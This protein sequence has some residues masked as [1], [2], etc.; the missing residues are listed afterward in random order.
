MRSPAKVSFLSSPFNLII[1]HTSMDDDQHTVSALSTEHDDITAIFPQT[2]LPGTHDSRSTD[3]G[4]VVKRNRLPNCVST[5]ILRKALFSWVW[6]HGHPISRIDSQGDYIRHWL[7]KIC[8]VE[9]VVVPNGVVTPSDK[10]MIPCAS[11]TRPARH[12]KKHGYNEDGSVFTEPSSKRK[13]VTI[14]DLI[15]K[16]QKLNDTVFDRKGWQSK[17]VSWMTRTGTSLRSASSDALYDL[18]TFHHPQV[19]QLV[20]R[21]HNTSRA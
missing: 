5:P 9:R 20:P 2:G 11:T 4:F 21:S 7:C 18:L 12:M 3:E 8:Y 14:T 17:Y 10:F 16:Q 1:N 15:N 6:D 13:N 19:E